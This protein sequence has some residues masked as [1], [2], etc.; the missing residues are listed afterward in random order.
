ML[1]AVIG[2][3]EV[4][5]EH[6]RHVRVGGRRGDDDLLGAACEVLGGAGAVGE[7][8]G[9]LD[10]D[11][12]AERLPRQR[13]GVALGEHLQLASVDHDRVLVLPRDLARVG[14]EDRVVLE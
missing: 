1:V 9:G 8:A 11:V 14:A 5:A 7:Q 3:V 4:D 10:H 2:L 12:H 13:G 6:D